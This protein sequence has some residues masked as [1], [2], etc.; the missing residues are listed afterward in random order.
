QNRRAAIP[1]SPTRLGGDPEGSGRRASTDVRL[2]G[3]RDRRQGMAGGEPLLDRRYRRGYPIREPEPGRIQRRP[4]ALA[5]ADRLSRQSSRPPVF[6]GRDR[7]GEGRLRG[8]SSRIYFRLG[9]KFVNFRSAV[10]A[11]TLTWLARLAALSR[12]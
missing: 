5:E 1:Q 11:G 10:A 12:N 6:Q 2:P 3:G 9:P 8:L 4:Q 7:Q